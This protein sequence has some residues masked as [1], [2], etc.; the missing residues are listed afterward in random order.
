MFILS[1]ENPMHRQLGH[2]CP[3]FSIFVGCQN[4]V[5]SFAVAIDFSEFIL[6]MGDE[7]PDPIYWEGAWDPDGGEF[8]GGSRA[9]API[10]R[11]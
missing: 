9:R 4:D 5:I 10:N 7:F 6:D 2:V 3:S 8:D 11:K 1:V